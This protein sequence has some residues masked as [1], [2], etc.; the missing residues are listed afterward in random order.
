M[1]M[2]PGGPNSYREPGTRPDWRGG[3]IG[4]F[5]NGDPS[6]GSNVSSGPANT[7]PSI[8]P[9]SEQPGP[10]VQGAPG[11]V[12]GMNPG[13]GSNAGGGFM[14]GGG[15][16]NSGQLNRRTSQP[17]GWARG[18][19]TGL[20]GDTNTIRRIV[21]QRRQQ[22]LQ[23]QANNMDPYGD[24]RRYDA[25]QRQRQEFTALQEQQPS[26]YPMNNVQNFETRP[27]GN[28]PSSWPGNQATPA[29]QVGGAVGG[30]ASQAYA[31][32]HG[33]GWWTQ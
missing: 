2:I 30:V 24:Q 22:A 21:D 25:A 3:S 16:T 19:G 18:S 9:P 29:Q 15:A 10:W 14:L 27:H 13:L 28:M 12:R 31:P 4:G 20:Q 17:T 26:Q 5:V 8:P 7:P 6:Q 33:W 11:N 32:Q 1:S 23:G